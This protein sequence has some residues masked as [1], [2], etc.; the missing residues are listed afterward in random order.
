MW[1]SVL[2]RTQ[3]GAGAGGDK[4]MEPPK[5]H[6]PRVLIQVEIRLTDKTIHLD[7]LGAV[8]D[9]AK[10]FLRRARSDSKFRRA[11]A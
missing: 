3:L 4:S 10:I 9:S 1:G 6:V 8:G 11:A 7:H 5:V 2:M